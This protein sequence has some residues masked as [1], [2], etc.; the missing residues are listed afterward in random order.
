MNTP[1]DPIHELILAAGFTAAFGMMFFVSELLYS[2]LKVEAEFTRKFIH[3]SCGSIAMMVAVFQ[4]HVITICCLGIFFSVLTGFMLSKG[5]LPSVHAVKRRS[6]GSVLYPIG[7]LLGVIFGM[8]SDYGA[9]FFIPMGIL[10]FSDTVAA[11]AGIRFPVVKY[12]VMGFSKSLG[13]S[14]GFLLTSLAVILI[15]QSISVHF[16]PLPCIVTILLVS[17]IAEALSVNGWDDLSVPLSVMGAM[18]LFG[19]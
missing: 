16:L 14:T 9:T 2:K 10:V 18:W 19:Y 11:L 4:V 5:L 3:I 8:R 12:K 15:Y 17:T 7:I 6:I 1:F 13:G